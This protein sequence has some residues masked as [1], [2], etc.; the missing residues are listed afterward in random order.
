MVDDDPVQIRRIIKQLYAI[1]GFSTDKADKQ[2]QEIELARN[3]HALFVY[4]QFNNVPAKVVGVDSG[5]P[6]IVY[7]L[8]NALHTLACQPIELSHDMKL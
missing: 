7:W 1:A 5:Q 4:S 3:E 2:E 6:W 8:S